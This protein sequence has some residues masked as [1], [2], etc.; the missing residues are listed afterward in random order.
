MKKILG[1]DVGTNSI[2]W[3]L[4]IEDQ[5]PKILGL[6]SRIF[7][8]AVNPK[9]RTP[10]NAKRRAKRMLRKIIARRSQ[11]KRSLE[12]MLQKNG[13]LPARGEVWEA[14]FS[15]HAIN[16]YVLRRKALDEPIELQELGRI[17]YHLCIHRGFKS[18]RK[19]MLSTMVNDPDVAAV[20][21]EEEAEKSLKPKKDDEEGVVLQAINELTRTLQEEGSRTLGEHLA[22]LVDAGGRARRGLGN[23]ANISRDM[24]EQEFEMVWEAQ[25]KHHKALTN[26][27][28]AQ[29]YRVIFFQRPLKI[30]RSTIENCPLEPGR[31]RAMKAQIVSQQFRIWQIINNLKFDTGTSE[32]Y[33]NL[34]KEQQEALAEKLNETEK[35]SWTSVRKAC[36]LKKETFNYEESGEKELK[37]DKTSCRIKKHIPELWESL[38]ELERDE[39]VHDLIHTDR[40]DGVI[41]RLRS[42]WK[43]T[44]HQAYK[45][46]T[47]ELD[48][49]T[50]SL[51]AKAMRKLLPVM[52]EGKRYDEACFEVYGQ[53]DP[54][55][56]EGTVEL[57]PLPDDARNPVVNKAM[58]ELRNVVN[59]IVREYGPIDIVR[60]E[61]ARD[62]KLTKKEKEEVSKRNRQNQKLN[63]EATEKIKQ[64]PAFQGVTPSHDDLEKYRLWVESDQTC[65]YTG[66]TV[67][68]ADL[69]GPDYDVEHII[70][71][72]RCWDDSFANKTICYAPENRSK[73]GKKTPKEAY[74][75]SELDA[76]KT[77]L[78]TMKFMGRA[79]KERFAMDWDDQQSERFLNRQITDTGYISKYARKFLAQLVGET[80]VQVS[81]GGSTALLRHR[82]GLNAVLGGTGKN[83]EDHRHHAVDALVIALISRGLFQQISKLSG[84]HGSMSLRSSEFDVPSPIPNLRQQA[85][86]W[87]QEMLVSHQTT[88]KITGALHEDTAYGKASPGTYVYRKAVVSLTTG[89]LQRVRDP[90]LQR[91]LSNLGS[92]KL[93]ASDPMEPFTYQDKYNRT[94]VVR[95]VRL[96]AAK[97]DSSMVDLGY[98]FHPKGSNHHVAVYENADG[99]RRYCVVSTY[100]AMRRVK[101][102]LK[103]YDQNALPG[104]RFVTAWHPNDVV[105][106]EG[107]PE[108]FYLIKSFSD[109][110]EGQCRKIDL[111]LRPL[112]RAVDS[113]N[114]FN[115]DRAGAFEEVR[116]KSPEKLALVGPSIELSILGHLK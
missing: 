12:N 8:E 39:F 82:W 116:C 5:E 15:D 97:R 96:T 66:R 64:L 38:S 59:A 107:R 103:L 62:L 76:I 83:R 100:D 32:G 78:A 89:E 88:R 75:E 9:D 94:R 17:F 6:G 90:R 11:R 74:S 98:K 77:R 23:A 28:R 65:P 52:R 37:G 68:F 40:I 42:H 115:P 41:K 49:G 92:D 48:S 7:Q 84:Q 53:K 50:T 21:A 111:F 91:E 16:P 34:N 101:S 24:I 19:A 44:P 27:L 108:R 60:I 56:R 86:P 55:T 99:E 10:K 80:N 112:R 20:I 33:K 72:P 58:H 69:F 73:K 106:V 31:K 25:A 36:G 22:N 95:S 114:H 67:A 51:S 102:G 46:A 79:K 110:D 29:V 18:N 4:V 30:Q 63:E 113:V 13:M 43:L 104:F 3:A 70:P 54:L 2:G 81:K 14:L 71:Y 1:I 35:L 85:L 61:L 47:L 105:E 87:I 109:N 93:K 57:L 26:T 45:V